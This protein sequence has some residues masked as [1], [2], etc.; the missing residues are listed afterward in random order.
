MVGREVFR[1]DH[2]VDG[3]GLY[4]TTLRIR[5]RLLGSGAPKTVEVTFWGGFIDEE[6]GVYNSEAPTAGGTALG[7][8]VVAF[9]KWSDNMGGGV[10]ANALLAAHGGL[11]TVFGAGSAR[12]VQ[13]RGHGYAVRDNLKVGDLRS[14]IRAI[15]AARRAK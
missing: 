10:A 2:P 5:G 14:R 15:R 1:V 6:H 3:D 9:Y 8:Q 13:G 11:Y 12:I 4:F 7:C